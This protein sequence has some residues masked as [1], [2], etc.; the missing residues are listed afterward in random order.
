MLS[1]TESIKS[2]K[3][4]KLILGNGFDLHCGLKSR[5]SDYFESPSNKDKFEDITRWLASFESHKTML[6]ADAIKAVDDHFADKKFEKTSCWDLFFAM[7]KNKNRTW[8]DVESVISASL[9]KGHENMSR[10]QSVLY[11]DDVQRIIT[12][13]LRSPQ[14][15]NLMILAAF[16]IKK[17]SSQIEP[18]KKDEFYYFLKNQLKQFENE[19]GCYIYNQVFCFNGFYNN[20]NQRFTNLVSKTLNDICNLDNIVSLDTFNFTPCNGLKEFEKIQDKIRYVNGDWEV[21]IFGIDSSAYLSNDARYIFSKTYRRMELDMVLDQSAPTP[22]FDN[23]I[24]FGHSLSPNDYSYFFP[25]LDKLGMT[26]YTSN[27]KI[28]FDYSVYG[29]QK[30]S[31]IRKSYCHAI[32]QLFESYASFKGMNETPGRLLDGL[33]T[34]GRVLLNEVEDIPVAR[35][36][37][38]LSP[39]GQ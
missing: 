15:A 16:V 25:L 4:V 27:S 22:D 33:T 23:A 26:N 8:S 10:P 32:Y 21:P 24:V 3:N 13:D 28:I 37:G 9:I 20:V 31:E 11:W 6:L 12:E 5:Y 38:Y 35:Q 34:Q 17:S 14:A 39:F 29:N 7:D 1:K 36:V 19:F 30:A 2:L 18:L